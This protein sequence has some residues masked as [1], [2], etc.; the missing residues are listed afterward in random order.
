MDHTFS[1]RSRK[2]LYL[3]SVVQSTVE[4]N[5]CPSWLNCSFILNFS[6]AAAA[7]ANDDA[8]ADDVRRTA[9]CRW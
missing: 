9:M 5:T 6:A 4:L 3:G 1:N 7:A 2:F 8:D